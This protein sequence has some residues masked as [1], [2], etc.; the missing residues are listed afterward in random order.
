ME[1]PKEYIIERKPIL[2]ARI[3]VNEKQEVKLVIP[4]CFTD[5]EIERLVN[6]KLNWINNQ[7]DFFKSEAKIELHIP[8][9]AIL[10]LGKSHPF[11]DMDLNKWYKIQSKKYITYKTNQLANQYHFKFN[12][13]FIRGSNTKWGNCSKDSNLS[14]N[15]R[16]IKAPE[17][18]IEYVIL[19]ELC[20]T[21]I[22]NHTQM[23]WLKLR[24]VCPNYLKHANWLK[25]YGKSMF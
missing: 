9:G 17:E 4:N 8:V 21:V 20:H 12:R 2:H 3:K 1:I 18:I 7:L 25:K 16:L 5:D 11:P 10:F 15:W 22:L 24:T 23:F 6:Q 13:L 14:F 19:H